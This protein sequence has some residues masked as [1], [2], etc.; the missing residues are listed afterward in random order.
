MSLDA[1]GNNVSEK[2]K[3]AV[4]TLKASDKITGF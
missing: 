2:Q 1:D 4:W 3:L